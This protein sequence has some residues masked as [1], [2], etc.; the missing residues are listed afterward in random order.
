MAVK[1][2]WTAGQVLTAAD[3]TDTFAAKAATPTF[4]LINAGGTALTGATSVTVSGISG[5]NWL[6]IRV[7]GASSASVSSYIS[8]QFNGDAAS[9]YSQ[10]GLIISNAV[11]ASSL[12]AT[13][14]INLGRMGTAAADTVSAQLILHGTKAAGI[15]PLAVGSST[16]AATGDAR[17]SVGHYVASAAITSVT[18]IS[19]VGNF[20]AG[21]IYV[22]GA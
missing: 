5:K 4:T 3:L 12:A 10:V 14:V 7:E 19:S 15:M 18:V 22:Y 16:S 2:S 17:S 11:A 6:L 20:D 1:T 21:T 13:T 8:L 9:N